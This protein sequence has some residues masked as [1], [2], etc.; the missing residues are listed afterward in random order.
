MKTLVTLD[1]RSATASV[2][3]CCCHQ[4]SKALFDLQAYSI[5]QEPIAVTSSPVSTHT[6]TLTH[7][8]SSEANETAYNN[9]VKYR[10][11]AA[12]LR[13]LR[14]NCCGNRVLC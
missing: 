13:S 11:E 4:R 8:T 5:N 2:S 9:L 7:I 14:L 1:L 12:Q 3:V 6:L 10:I